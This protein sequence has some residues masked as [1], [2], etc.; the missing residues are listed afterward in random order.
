[1]TR[2]GEGGE[3]PFWSY[4]DLALFLGAILPSFAVAAGIV[5]AGHVKGQTSITLLYQTLTYLLLLGVLYL[6]VARRYGRPFWRSLRWTGRFRGAWLCAVAGPALAIMTVIL[7]VVLREPEIRSPIEDLISDRRSLVVM[8]LFI[9]VFGPVFEELTFR[10]FLFPL[11]AR[12]WGPWAGILFT[13]ALF[14]LVHG[15]QYRWSWQRL[16]G[17][18]LAG[19]VFGYAR[20]KTGST[21]ASTMVHASFNTTVFVAYLVQRSAR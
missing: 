19:V 10:G 12:S 7:G 18:G 8:G 17:V 14:A 20:F 21:F 11:L 9:M 3:Y 15:N 1:M 13:A 6:L 16:L 2:P 5:R 4:E